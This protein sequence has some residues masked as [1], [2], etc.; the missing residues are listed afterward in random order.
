[1]FKPKRIIFV[2]IFLALVVWIFKFQRNYPATVDLKHDPDTFGVTYSTKFA[3]ELGF[4]NDEP[5][6]ALLDD[7]KVKNVRLPIY[8][9]DI[10]KEDG[11]L[12]FSKYDKLLA[13]GSNRGTKFIVNIGWRLPR[14]PECHAPA[15]LNSSSTEVIQGKALVMLRET[16]NHYLKKPDIASNIVYWQVE[17]EPLLDVFG[18]CP[19][20]DEAFL[21]KEIALVRALD[22]SHPIIITASGELSAWT[23]EGHLGDWFGTT[24]YRVVWN[25]YFGY[26]H[27][28]L[29]AFFY[30]SK[31]TWA[32][33][34]KDKSMIVELQAEPWVPSGSM[35]DMAPADYEKSMSLE[36]FR[37]NIQVG[38][39]SGFKKIYLWGAEW[40][41]FQKTKGQPL[42]WEVA[43]PLFD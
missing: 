42:Y 27:Y 39:D 9:D 15:W 29:P 32:R 41:Y 1:M 21:Q 28:P 35:K 19:K 25:K 10:E 31:A 16:V 23:K 30:S 20:G 34:P 26:I 13:D 3:Q 2:L 22:P 5:Y 37:G 43:R 7:L 12:D 14:W 6:Y 36:Q 4:K 8:W 18:T 40:W 38:L 17:N 11:V 33:V 24:M